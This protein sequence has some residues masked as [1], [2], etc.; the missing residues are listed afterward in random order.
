MQPV[1]IAFSCFLKDFM[2]RFNGIVFLVVT[3]NRDIIHM[4]YA[5]ICL[6]Q[7]TKRLIIRL[8]GIPKL[9]DGAKTHAEWNIGPFSQFP[10]QF[11][12]FID[13]F[14]TL[15]IIQDCFFGRYQD[16]N[17]VCHNRTDN[18]RKISFYN[19]AHLMIMIL[20][21][22]GS[23]YDIGHMVSFLVFT[24]YQSSHITIIRLQFQQ[25]FKIFNIFFKVFL[26]QKIIN[27]TVFNNGNNGFHFFSYNQLLTSFFTVLINHGHGSL[28]NI[29]DFT[30]F[31]RF[32]E[33]FQ[34]T[35]IDCFFCII[36]LIICTH[37]YKNGIGIVT[38]DFLHR[39]DSVNS[40]HL[41]VHKCNVRSEMLSK[42]NHISSGFC[43]FNLA[44]ISKFF[45]YNEA[46]RIYHN[47]FII[48]QHNLIHGFPPFLW[49]WEWK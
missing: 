46:K 32:I 44:C 49:K 29:D 18:T 21:T 37:D 24:K 2:L 16:G 40:G 34:N 42:L 27:Q 17:F 45:F 23:T 25:C 35:Q 28:Y 43:R 12:G 30:L 13:Q 20:N 15:I 47:S 6:N 41:D 36:K 31:Y 1:H 3:G 39:F 8:H 19:F 9:S 4:C 33:I 38:P 14:N 11:S 5:A 48:R 7:G 26:K 22:N 10:H